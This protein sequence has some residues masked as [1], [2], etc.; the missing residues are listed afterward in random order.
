MPI[1]PIINDGITKKI[2]EIII[3]IATNSPIPIYCPVTLGK[4]KF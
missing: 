3:L 2:K 1:K 4:V